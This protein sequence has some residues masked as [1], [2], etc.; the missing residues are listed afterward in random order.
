[1]TVKKAGLR[2]GFTVLEIMIAVTIFIVAFLGT[3]AYKYGAALNTRRAD[4]QTAATRTALLLCEGW[5][6]TSGSTTYNPVP[7]LSDDLDISESDGPEVP[8]GFI[9]LGSFDVLI[10]GTNYYV[11]LSYQNIG[12][13]LRALSVVVNWDPAGQDT[14]ELA[15][16]TKSYRLTTYVE[17]PGL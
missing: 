2:R 1:M 5:N 7:A 4:L 14:H 15:D 6:G 17:N 8:D 12:A 3:S 11:T 16:A 10:E 13:D 9:L